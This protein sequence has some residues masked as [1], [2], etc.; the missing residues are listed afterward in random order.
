[1]VLKNLDVPFHCTRTGGRVFRKQR[2]IRVGWMGGRRPC[3][4]KTVLDLEFS[5]AFLLLPFLCAGKDKVKP[6]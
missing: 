1:M 2:E 4:A 5:E 6:D 3:A